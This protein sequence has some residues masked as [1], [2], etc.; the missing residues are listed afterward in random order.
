MILTGLDVLLSKHPDLVADKAVGL[1]ANYASVT[2]DNR[3]SVEAIRALGPRSLVVFGPEHGYWGDVQYME[4]SAAPQYRDIPIRNLY[5]G[6]SGHALFPEP[7]ELKE[8]DV[9]LIDL[10]DVGARY[11]TYYAS[12]ANC[13]EVAATTGT[14]VVVLDRPNPING[15]AIEGP[16]L[17]PPFIAF[18]GQYPIPVRHGM[19]IGELALLRNEVVGCELEVIAMEGWKRSMW[20]SDTGRPWVHPSPN[21]PTSDTTIVYPGTC[22][23]E[24][25]NLSE[26][27]GTT[28]PFEVFGAPWLDAFALSDAMNELAL[29]GVQFEP[30][31]YMPAFSKHAGALCNGARLIVTDREIF[32]PLRTGVWCIATARRLD[33]E[34]F[35]WNRETY[36]WANCSAIDALI[37]GIDFRALVDTGGDL[38]GWITSWRANETRFARERIPHLRAE[39]DDPARPHLPTRGDDMPISIPSPRA[40]A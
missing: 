8:L 39:Y 12:M 24:G 35:D 36:E 7:R 37:G 30:F 21:I 34:H 28:R 20:W 11:Y 26:G 38:E 14:R 5:E 13:M 40:E 3:S 9:L 10:Q 25:T 31:R 27:R 6:K 32:E 18:V 4:E 29:R 33:P 1:L 2:R 23:F 17:R 22:L 15:N 16:S 19:T